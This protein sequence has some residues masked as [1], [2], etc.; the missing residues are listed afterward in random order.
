MELNVGCGNDNWGDLRLDV[1]LR[2]QLGDKNNPN[3]IASAQ[4]LP[5][6]N[7]SFDKVRCYHVLEHLPDPWIAIREIRR[8]S[9]TATLRFPV[10]DGFKRHLVFSISRL[11]WK[12]IHSAYMTRKLRAHLWIIR[13][14]RGK[15]LSRKLIP[16]RHLRNFLGPFCPSIAFEWEVNLPNGDV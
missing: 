14:K 6:R 8:V 3:I 4:A 16:F 15:I 2:N 7:N 10:D 9:R 11:N 13:P 1:S 5:F 12:D